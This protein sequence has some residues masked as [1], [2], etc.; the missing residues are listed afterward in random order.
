MITIYTTPVCASCVAVKKYLTSKNVKYK[1]VDI[2]ND[3]V[4]QQ[5][6]IQ[7]TGMAS[8]PVTMRGL[9][10]VVGFSVQ[11]LAKLIA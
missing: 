6:I 9:D 8:V 10:F 2:S 3:A 4:L 5:K 11:K 1:E 7:L